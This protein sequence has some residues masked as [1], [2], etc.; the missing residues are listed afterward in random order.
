MDIL[1]KIFWLVALHFVADFHL[2]SDF[3]AKNKRPGS[4]PIWHW[5]LTAHSLLHGV[6]VAFVL[7]PLFGL[8]EALTHGLID[9]SKESGRLGTGNKGFIMDQSLHLGLKAI[10]LGIW[11]LSP[12]IF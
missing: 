9:Y 2:Q 4:S 7:N 11:V 10:W 1:E 5:V 6:M 3:I 8:F 12:G